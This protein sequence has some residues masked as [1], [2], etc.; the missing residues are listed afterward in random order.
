MDRVRH[1][2]PR[3][4]VVTG[5][6]SGLGLEVAR[7]LAARGMRVVL[8][9]RTRAKAEAAART[10]AGTVDA[11]ALDVGDDDCVD[12]FFRWLDRAV[13]RLD[14]LVHSAGAL[15]DEDDAATLQV[16]PAVLLRALDNNAVGALRVGQPALRRMNDAGFGRIVAVSS[17]LGGLTTMSPGVPAYRIS[18]T[19]LN[20]VVRMLSL[21][22]DD[23]VLVNSVCPGWCKTAMGGPGANRSVTQG[24]AGIVW[25]ATLPSSGPHGGFFRDGHALPW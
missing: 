7:E 22:A 9:A 19:A 25:A 24:A 16:T 15:F 12:A 11:A 14:I 1:R 21:E 3:V 17:E 4:A 2:D 6:A 20:A 8:T 23:G 10:V 13:G 18:K 5:G